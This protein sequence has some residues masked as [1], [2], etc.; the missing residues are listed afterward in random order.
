MKEYKGIKIHDDVSEMG[1][2]EMSLNIAFMKNKRAQYR[3]FEKEMDV[4]DLVKRISKYHG[5]N[6]DQYDNK[7][8]DELMS[9]WS[10][11]GEDEINGQIALLYWSLCG[12]AV[13]RELTKE[14]IDK[15]K[16]F[17]E[18]AE[19]LDAIEL[20][21]EKGMRYIKSADGIWDVILH[22]KGKAMCD[23]IPLLD[24]YNEYM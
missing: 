15:N 10:V 20:A 22:E 21:E 14:L 11:Y 19:L 16:K 23:S 24:W 17:G 3:D 2:F 13:Y 7:E 1:M 12:M 4:A 6:L 5:R 18:K 9:E 8:I